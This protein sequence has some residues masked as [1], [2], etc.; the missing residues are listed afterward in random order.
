M[1]VTVVEVSAGIS[2]GPRVSKECWD[3]T[4]KLFSKPRDRRR[5]FFSASREREIRSPSVIGIV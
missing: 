5:R 4:V 1:V 3:N 2:I